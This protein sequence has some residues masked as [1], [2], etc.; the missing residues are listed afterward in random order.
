MAISAAL[1]DVVVVEGAVAACH[2][3]VDVSVG[4]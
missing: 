2:Q 3:T 4:D 1:D